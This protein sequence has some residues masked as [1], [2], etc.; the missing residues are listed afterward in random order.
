MMNKKEIMK[1]FDSIKYEGIFCKKVNC[2]ECEGTDYT[3]EPN[4]YGCSDE[5]KYIEK[6]YNSILKRRIKIIDNQAGITNE[7]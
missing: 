7:K 3:G 1:D 2:S 4:G 6:R 5:E